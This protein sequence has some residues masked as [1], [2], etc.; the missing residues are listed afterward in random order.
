MLKVIRGSYQFLLNFIVAFYAG[1]VI[2]RERD[3]RVAEITDASP[4]PNWL[5]LVAKTGALFAVV[6]VF[7]TAGVLA[8]I[9]YQ[10]CHGYTDLELGLY[11]RGMLLE[12]VPFVLMAAAAVFLQVISNQKFIGYAAVHPRVRAAAR[13][14]EPRSASTTSTSLAAPQS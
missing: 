4:V 10:L 13:A 7:M 8:T 2:W 5:P 9:G 12:S 14:A 11:L 6:L 3:A 1:E